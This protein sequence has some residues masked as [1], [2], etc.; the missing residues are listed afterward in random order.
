MEADSRL[1]YTVLLQVRDLLT[2]KTFYQHTL[3]LEKPIVDSSFWVEFAVPNVGV[4]VLQQTNIVAENG[5]PRHGISWLLPVEKLE[6]KLD[7]M[8][9]LG[10]LPLRP[11]IEI[12]GRR[13]ITFSD[14]EGNLFTF[15]SQT[16]EPT[17]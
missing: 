15:Y 2:V 10:I 7:E 16:G 4:L 5:G 3:K 6:A 14:P 1:P 11:P 8:N 17:G 13:S 9:G 12:P